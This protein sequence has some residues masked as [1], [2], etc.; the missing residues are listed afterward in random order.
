MPCHAL[1]MPCPALVHTIFAIA[2]AIAVT[3]TN[4]FT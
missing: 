3:V 2:I 1:S 4:I